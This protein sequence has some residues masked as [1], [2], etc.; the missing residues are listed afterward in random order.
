M[1][2]KFCAS[3]ADCRPTGNRYCEAVF[4]I[5]PGFHY[6]NFQSSTATR[7][8]IISSLQRAPRTFV[9]LIPKRDGTIHLQ[10]AVTRYETESN[11]RILT[12]YSLLH[13]ADSSY[14]EVIQSSLDQ[15]VVLFELIAPRAAIE[16]NS[17]LKSL[18]IPVFPPLALEETARSLNAIAQLSAMNLMQPDWYIA[19]L[20]RECVTVPTRKPHNFRVSRLVLNTIATFLPCPE[21]N[22]TIIHA[23]STRTILTPN[24][25]L[26]LLSADLVTK[27]RLTYAWRAV[28][29][30][31]ANANARVL[32]DLGR[33]RVAWEALNEIHE[34]DVALLYGAWH[35]GWFCRRAEADGMK[36]LSQEWTTAMVLPNIPARQSDTVRWLL[37]A[38]LYCTYA[39]LDWIGC[40]E[41]L[42]QLFTGSHHFD[43][44]YLLLYLL[45][46]IAPY[47][48]FRRWI[49]EWD[50]ASRTDDT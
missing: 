32:D 12:L 41:R 23:F 31:N 43:L 11:Q 18:R 42:V 15:T 2:S 35:T 20:P 22:A 26:Q 10:T 21:L 37:A 47:W 29:S 16:D 33:N 34:R 50:T 44:S 4:V 45:R 27:R 38:V 13:I 6:K 36:F 14:Y 8:R 19:D 46:H 7:R 3:L 30:T 48:A 28:A 9:R 39:G 5:S 25:L 40:V 1:P 24:R 17:K 49:D